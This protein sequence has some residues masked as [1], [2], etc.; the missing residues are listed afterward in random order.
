MV[1][2]VEALLGDLH[3]IGVAALQAHADVVVKDV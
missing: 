1:D 2:P 3:Q